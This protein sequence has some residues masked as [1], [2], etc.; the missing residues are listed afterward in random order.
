MAATADAP[1]WK[2]VLIDS[3]GLILVVWSIPVAI[4]LIGAP[5]VLLAGAVIASVRWL[6]Q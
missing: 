1:V 3:A 4:I 5:I 2:T 6:V